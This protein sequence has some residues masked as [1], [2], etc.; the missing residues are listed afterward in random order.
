MKNIPLNKINSN[1]DVLFKKIKYW[2]LV[3]N[4]FPFY[5]IAVLVNL[6]ENML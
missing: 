1:S 2:Q 4:L 6:I 5:Y 3:V